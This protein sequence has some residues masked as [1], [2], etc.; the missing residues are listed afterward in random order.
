MN[1]RNQTK[2]EGSGLFS[3]VFP[4]K[5]SYILSETFTNKELDISTSTIVLVS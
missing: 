3:D 4:M 1:Q 5:K 2:F